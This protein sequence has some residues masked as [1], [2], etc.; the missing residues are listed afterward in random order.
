MGGVVTF[1]VGCASN[2]TGL[3]GDAGCPVGLGNSHSGATWGN[4][5]QIGFPDL[6]G[7]VP[8]GPGAEV[9]LTRPR[10][11]PQLAQI[12]SYP[13]EPYETPSCPSPLA[14]MPPCPFQPALRR[15]TRLSRAMPVQP[16]P[17]E[18]ELGEDSDGDPMYDNPEMPN[19]TFYDNFEEQVEAEDADWQFQGGKW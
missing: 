6:A 2:Q 13:S 7:V 11:E 5:A 14:H 12:P 16:T 15:S 8:G 4:G 18:Q 17:A 3:P 19:D 10:V 1:Q 9:G